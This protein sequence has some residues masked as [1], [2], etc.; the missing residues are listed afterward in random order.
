MVAIITGEPR[1]ISLTWNKTK[2]LQ[3]KFLTNL[4]TKM[5]QETVLKI[6]LNNIPNKIKAEL[7]VKKYQLWK[8]FDKWLRSLA[9]V[10]NFY[11]LS[12]SHQFN[13]R[14]WLKRWRFSQK[15]IQ[16][17]FFYRAQKYLQDRNSNHKTLGS[18]AKTLPLCHWV[19]NFH[20][21]LYYKK[22]IPFHR[23]TGY[24]FFSELKIESIF[25]FNSLKIFHNSSY[26]H[27]HSAYVISSWRLE[28][29]G[30]L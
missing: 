17:I 4:T 16:M 25:S 15:N 28:Y 11:S 12:W 19:S 1:A 14:Q 2:I 29:P 30:Q 5:F 27:K 10:K 9:V 24:C 18:E 3:N 20:F 26:N 22:I 21:R 23:F 7:K 13:S 6:T 8:Q